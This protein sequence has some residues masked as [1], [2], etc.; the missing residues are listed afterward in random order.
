MVAQWAPASRYVTV[1]P[2][3]DA[4]RVRLCEGFSDA[5][6]GWACAANSLGRRRRSLRG[7]NRGGI[8]RGG[9]GGSV[10][11]D[12]TAATVSAGRCVACWTVMADAVE[13]LGQDVDKKA[14]DELGYRQGHGLVQIAIFGAVVLTP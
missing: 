7:R 14:S 5:C 13:A 6:R 12:L 9:S 10:Y 2:L 4:A 1:E 8:R 11:G 3:C